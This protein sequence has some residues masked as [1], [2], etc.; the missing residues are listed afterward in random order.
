MFLRGFK[1]YF[2]LFLRALLSLILILVSQTFRT[3]PPPPEIP[4]RTGL[5][6]EDTGL[7][8]IVGEKREPKLKVELFQPVRIEI[9]DP[10]PVP[11]YLR[12][13]ANEGKHIRR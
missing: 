5:V 11:D 3:V 2:R 4:T 13:A 7:R 1:S 9:N 6:R 10:E 8:K 12:K